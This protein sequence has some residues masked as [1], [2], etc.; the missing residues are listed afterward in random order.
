MKDI[1]TVMSFT[2]KEMVKRKSFI[3]STVFLI[4]AIVIGFNIPKI[5]SAIKGDEDNSSRKIVIYAEDAEFNELIDSI[6]I[7]E[8]EIKKAESFEEAKGLIIDETCEFGFKFAKADSPY[9]LKLTYLAKN[10]G[11]LTQMPEV[12]VQAIQSSFTDYKLLKSGITQV[13]I[14]ESKPIFDTSIEFVGE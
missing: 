10:G 5:I 13:Q 6:V 4:A 3:I 7:P 2:M 1:F 14:Q 12:V 11:A 8:T 9:N